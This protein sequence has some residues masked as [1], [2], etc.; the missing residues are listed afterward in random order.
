MSGSLGCSAINCVHNLG[1]LCSANT[2]HVIGMRASTSS[3][4][5]CETFAERSLRNA[6]TH[7]ANM[8]I[9]GEIRQLFNR[10]AVHMSPKILCE[11]VDCVYNEA[12]I[13]SAGSI[14]INGPHAQTTEH[15]NCETFM[16]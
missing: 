10:D 5:H 1:G 13:C 2:I 9:P 16:P 14:Q 15:T 4:T 6:L 3:E 11:A 12:R 7:V 8:N